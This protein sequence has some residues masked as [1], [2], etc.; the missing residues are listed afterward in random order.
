MNCEVDRLQRLHDES[1]RQGN[2][3]KADIILDKIDTLID[4]VDG[5]TTNDEDQP[6]NQQMQQLQES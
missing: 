6:K 1:I 2:T 5:F 3:E 4:E